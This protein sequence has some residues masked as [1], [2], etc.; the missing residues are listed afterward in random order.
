MRDKIALCKPSTYVIWC[1][2]WCDSFTKC[3]EKLDL[4]DVTYVGTHQILHLATVGLLQRSGAAHVKRLKQVGCM[5]RETLCHNVVLLAVELEGHGV[6]AL[7]TVE[8][9]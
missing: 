8:R 5:R 1:H 7:V 4:A 9:Q 2:G 6:M 3:T